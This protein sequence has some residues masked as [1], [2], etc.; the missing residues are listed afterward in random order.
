MLAHAR[1]I[2]RALTATLVAVMLVMVCPCGPCSPAAAFAMAPADAAA[3]AHAEMVDASTDTDA[4]EST[5]CC[6]GDAANDGDD[7]A[8]HLCA[9][10]ESDAALQA[11]AEQVVYAV[12]PQ[13]LPP[14]ALLPSAGLLSAHWVASAQPPLVRRASGPPPYTRVIPTPTRLALLATLRC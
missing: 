9:H 6:P 2:I 1:Q 13:P 11:S 8:Q 12:A 7:D 5:G 14:A 4:S 10:C 3:L